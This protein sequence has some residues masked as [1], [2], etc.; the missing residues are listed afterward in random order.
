MVVD[1]GLHQGVEER[2]MGEATKEFDAY[3]IIFAGSGKQRFQPEY[4]FGSV[5]VGLTTYK[6]KEIIHDKGKF[7]NCT[8]CA[9][10]LPICLC[11]SEI[12][13]L[14]LHINHYQI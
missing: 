3:F 13:K 9:K 1:C 7:K 5:L 10:W 11:F 12:S 6:A 8:R 14:N 2:I 4:A